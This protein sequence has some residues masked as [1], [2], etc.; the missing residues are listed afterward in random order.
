MTRANRAFSMDACENCC[1][2][3]EELHR[4][5]G[6]VDWSAI[7]TVLLDMDGTLLDRY[8]DDYFWHHYVPEVYGQENGIEVSRAREILRQRY[9]ARKGTLEWT[10]L[11]FWSQELLLDIPALKMQVDYLISIHPYVIDFLRF[12]RRLN[13][14]VYLVTNAHSKTLAIKM[15]KT[16]L[17]GHFDRIVCSLEVGMA[18]ENPVFWRNLQVMLAFDPVRTL[19]ADDTEAVLIAAREYGLEHLIY[20]ARPSSRESIKY[21]SFFPSIIYFNELIREEKN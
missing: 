19:L 4:T 17:G 13:K 1:V 2:Q 15:Q 5:S 21:S 16:A 18:K 10:D 12:C 9:D 8:F 6:M 14:K 11:D 7:D 20:V 3:A